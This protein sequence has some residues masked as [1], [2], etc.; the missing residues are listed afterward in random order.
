MNWGES[1]MTFKASLFNKGLIVSDLKR[2]WWAS[3]LYGLFLIMILPFHHMMQEIPADN[4]WIKEMLQ[5]SLDI[6]SGQNGLQSVLICTVPVI[7]AVLIFHY[8]HNSRAA[9]VMHSLPFNRKT[10]FCSHSAAGLVLLLVPVI[11]TGLVLMALNATTHLK[12]YYSLLNILQWMGMTALFDALLFSITV[13]V[14]MFTGNAVAHI[15]FTYILQLLPTGL[16]LLLVENLRYLIYG[17]PGASH[18]G[19]LRYDFPLM[20]FA[21]G[22]KSDLFTAGTVTVYF[23]IAALFL[24]AAAYVYK[25]RHAEAAGEV[26]AFSTMR[27]VFKYGVTVCAMLLL[28]VYF[29][30][31]SGE[32]FYVI[33]VGYVVGSLLGY[34]IAESLLQKSLQ[35]WSSYKGYLIYAAV[36]MVLLLGIITDVT[37]YVR[38]VPEAK[39]VKEV[40]FGAN[41]GEWE[42]PERMQEMKERSSE[43]GGGIFLKDKNNIK[44]ITLLHRQLLEKPRDQKWMLRYIGYTLDNGG[45]LIRQYDID[46]K[47]YAS[48]LKPIYESLE[49][50]QA[51]FPV[52]TQAPAV[53]KLI[54]I[55]DYRTSKRPAILSNSVEIG[56]FAARLKQDVLHATFEELTADTE[57]NVRI[58]IE[59]VHGKSVHY[60]LRPGYRSVID[61]LKQKG[62]YENIMLLPEE[63]EY[64]ALES[65]MHSKTFGDDP[66]PNRVVIRDRQL[67]EELL[68]IN[69]PIDFVDANQGK[70][71]DV[72]FSGKTAAGSF[73]FHRSIHRDWPVSEKLKQYMNQLDSA[74]GS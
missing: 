70:I 4:S 74:I 33:V 15:V 66:A 62:Y 47:R 52:A 43:Y 25:L 61:W 56:E 69:L 5:R 19:S 67:I 65:F 24:A 49:Y 26:V 14:G 1:A 41:Y 21:G 72:T 55:T 20:M 13:F 6:F 37:G 36:I 60:T 3:A 54:E 10:L 42:Y 68:N 63:I 12:E 45:Y 35:V 73:N 23:L 11:V 22:T 2:F 46:E 57:E 31:V 48:L 18:P 30:G 29:A 16:Y 7:L 32:A 51:R 64:A 17:Y 58:N 9:A 44:N 59:D 50:K 27:P 40:Y 8:L 71:I 39:N 34:L 53:I 38:R 28:G